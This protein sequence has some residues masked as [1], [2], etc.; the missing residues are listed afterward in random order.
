MGERMSEQ[1]SEL[2]ADAFSSHSGGCVRDC[3]C[4]RTYF[5]P[6]GGWD[7]GQGELEELRRRAAEHPDQCV[8]VDYTVTAMVVGGEEIVDGCCCDLA[9]WYEN[10]ICQYSAQITTYYRG[11]AE[12]L[13]AKVGQLEGRET[14]GNA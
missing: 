6:D 8:E 3:A 9:R 10:L 13:R 4:G 11:R 7:W 14:W 5:N 12:A 2:F 1:C